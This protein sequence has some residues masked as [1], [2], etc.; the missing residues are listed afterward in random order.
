[1]VARLGQDHLLLSARQHYEA[2]P[3][4][5]E[6]SPSAKKRIGGERKNEDGD[7]DDDDEPLLSAFCAT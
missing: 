1:M 2:V 7:D 5:P 4:A 6:Q 3:C